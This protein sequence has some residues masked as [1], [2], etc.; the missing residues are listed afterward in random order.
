MWLVE[1]NTNHGVLL[2]GNTRHG[3]R[4]KPAS[5]ER[6]NALVK[7]LRVHVIVNGL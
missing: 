4:A 2:L 6:D 1:E 7:H 3:G 5:A